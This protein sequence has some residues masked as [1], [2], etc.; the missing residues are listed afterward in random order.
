ML[1]LHACGCAGKGALQYYFVVMFSSVLKVQIRKERIKLG[2][3]QR[4]SKRREQEWEVDLTVLMAQ[5]TEQCQCSP[6]AAG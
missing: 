6:K 1:K 5:C 3:H 4:N 2:A